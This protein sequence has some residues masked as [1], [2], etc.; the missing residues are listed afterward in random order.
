[1]RTADCCLRALAGARSYVRDAGRFG[2]RRHLAERTTASPLKRSTNEAAIHNPS[3]FDF[4]FSGGEGAVSHDLV[5]H[6]IPNSEA[7]SRDGAVREDD[8][9]QHRASD[10]VL[11]SIARSSLPAAGSLRSQPMRIGG[12]F[13]T[14]QA[15]QLIARLCSR[16]PQIPD[17]DLLPSQVSVDT[18]LGSLSRH[19]HSITRDVNEGRTLI[20]P[21]RVAV[22]RAGE[23]ALSTSDGEVCFPCTRLIDDE[24]SCRTHGE[25]AS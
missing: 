10:F 21:R 3:R 15:G 9:F 24:H 25:N 4:A 16:G 6:R 20:E 13:L 23:F 8:A 22:V 7:V 17:F 1:M 18:D 19:I 12:C 5:C 14:L 2:R 11:T